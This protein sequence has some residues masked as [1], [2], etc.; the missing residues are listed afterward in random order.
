MLLEVFMYK[1]SCSGVKCQLSHSENT[2][3]HLLVSYQMN[4]EN[5]YKYICS[6]N[7]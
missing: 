1:L 5:A 4:Y 3:K 2:I 7:G 6:E